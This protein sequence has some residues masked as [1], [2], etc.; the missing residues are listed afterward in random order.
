MPTTTTNDD[1]VL[2]DAAAALSTQTRASV[3]HDTYDHDNDDDARARVDLAVR[4]EPAPVLIAARFLDR[5]VVFARA[6]RR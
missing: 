5:F 3:A 1:V 6:L 2:L 4:D